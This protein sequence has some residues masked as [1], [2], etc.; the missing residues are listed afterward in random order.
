M[1]SFLDNEVTEVT[2]PHCGNQHSERLGHLK[3][4][5][6]LICRR[7]R[8]GLTVDADQLRRKIEQVEQAL[9]DINGSLRRALK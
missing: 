3:T 5:P 2:C 1:D 8:G 9:A 4:N 6:V 7:C